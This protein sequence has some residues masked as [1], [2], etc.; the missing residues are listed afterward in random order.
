MG[1]LQL[2]VL[3]LLFAGAYADSQVRR[4]V[5]ARDFDALLMNYSPSLVAA[6]VGGVLVGICAAVLA[7]FRSI[8]RAY[9]VA[10]LLTAM[11]LFMIATLLVLGDA[12][13][14]AFWQ[15]SRALVSRNLQK[16]EIAALV[17][18]TVLVVGAMTAVVAGF[19]V[20]T[21]ITQAVRR[22]ARNRRETFALVR[23]PL[24]R[25]IGTHA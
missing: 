22:A 1:T 7:P 10:L 19:T 15:E 14:N 12:G 17:I 20:R 6:V 4:G 24:A 23:R 18:G 5:V 8:V 21:G 16:P 25:T 9:L 3:V 13:P 11:P 2:A